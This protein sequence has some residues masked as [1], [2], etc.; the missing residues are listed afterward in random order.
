[1]INVLAD[2]YPNSIPEVL[3][4]SGGLLE[5]V[6]PDGSLLP[7]AGNTVVF[8]L[9]EEAKQALAQVQQELHRRCGAMLAEPLEMPTFHLTLHDLANGELLPQR[10]EMA[11]KAK[12][13]LDEIRSAK[14]PAIA[15]KATWTFN[16]VS[17]SI[18]LGFEPANREAWA[19]LDALYERFQQIRPLSYGLT[20]HITMAYFRP[21]VYKDTAA[22]KQ[23]VGPVEL[24]V[25]LELDNLV[26]QDFDHMNAYRT[27]Y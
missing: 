1:M 4:T 13:A 9:P 26:L 10:E 14:L 16:M 2:Y 23:A 17:T 11:A 27:V 12:I 19:Q 24:E 8:L 21:G 20:P 15:M 6:A 7:F 3:T 5:K 18:V 25:M 22:L